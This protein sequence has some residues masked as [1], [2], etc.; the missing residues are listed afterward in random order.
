MPSFL[1]PQVGSLSRSEADQLERTVSPLTENSSHFSDDGSSVL[2]GPR[3]RAALV[4][5]SCARGFLSRRSI[6]VRQRQ[7]KQQMHDV[8]AFLQVRQTR[9]IMR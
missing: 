4:L 1:A 9:T 2:Q 6:V 7:A 5:Q 8:E 3:D